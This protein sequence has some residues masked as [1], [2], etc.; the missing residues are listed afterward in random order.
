MKRNNKLIIILVLLTVLFI[1]GAIVILALSDRGDDDT[2]TGLQEENTHGS[3]SL[4]CTAPDSIPDHS[5]EDYIILNDGIPCFNEWDID[6][7]TGEH[8]R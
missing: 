5:G 3:L 2:G 8:Y 4:V 7:I 1:A 6:N